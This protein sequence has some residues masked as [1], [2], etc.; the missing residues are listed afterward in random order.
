MLGTEK[1]VCEMTAKAIYTTIIK[2]TK[3]HNRL[4]PGGSD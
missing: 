4:P 1:G 2:K 3:Q